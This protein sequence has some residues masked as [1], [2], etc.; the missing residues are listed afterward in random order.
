MADIGEFRIQKPDSR[1]QKCRKKGIEC[2]SSDSGTLADLA[3]LA[4]G[5]AMGERG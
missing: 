5:L 1:M 3:S 2:R 4:V